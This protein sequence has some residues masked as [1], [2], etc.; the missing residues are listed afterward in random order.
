MPFGL[1][2]ASA[3]YQRLMDKVSK[4]LIKKNFEVYVDDMVGKSLSPDQH[5]R[6]LTKIF[7]QLIKHN[8]RL[9]PEKCTFWGWWR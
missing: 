8:M 1:K 5:A 4:E 6:D 7:A 3:M 9:N 2:N